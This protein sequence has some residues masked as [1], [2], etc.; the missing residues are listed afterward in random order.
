MKDSFLK[1]REE[2]K[3]AKEN[4]RVSQEVL[5]K[6]Y[7][8]TPKLQESQEEKKTKTVTIVMTPSDKKKLKEL[9]LKYNQSISDVISH[10]IQ[11]SE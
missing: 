5:E 1:A 8:S 6:A 2:S 7:P 3:L 4:K 9:S 10:W 11:N